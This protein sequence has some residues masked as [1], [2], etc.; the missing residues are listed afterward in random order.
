MAVKI[1]LKRMGAKKRAFYRV[2]ATD[3][4]NKRDGKVI[5]ELGYYDPIAATNQ[6]KLDHEKVNKWL[7][8]G[9]IP[10]DTARTLLKKDGILKARFEAK[11]GNG[12]KK[13]AKKETKKATKSTTKKA[14]KT[15]KKS[16]K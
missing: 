16:E 10:T 11:A 9:A 6:L 13:E 4:R 14:T 1:R 3:S 12:A 2:V 7:D 8:N 5:E 15:T